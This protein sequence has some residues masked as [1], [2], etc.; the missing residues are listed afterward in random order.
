MKM[1]VV[2][3]DVSA[4][5]AFAQRILAAGQVLTVEF[6]VP[7]ELFSD[8][9]EVAGEQEAVVIFTEETP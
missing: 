6:D 4:L 1:V 2:T 5:I 3:E 8:L 9:S 7:S